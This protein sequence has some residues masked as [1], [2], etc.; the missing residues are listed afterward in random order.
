MTALE[1]LRNV[2]A[3]LAWARE[4]PNP[5]D[6]EIALRDL[7]HDLAAELARLEASMAPTRRVRLDDFNDIPQKAQP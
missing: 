2:L 1:L 7:E 5:A 3:R 6:R 4:E